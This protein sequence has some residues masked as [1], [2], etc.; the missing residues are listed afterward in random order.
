MNDEKPIVVVVNNKIRNRAGGWGLSSILAGILSWL[1]NHSV[2]WCVV[3]FLL[4]WI[5]LLYAAL[6]R[7]EEVG[8]VLTRVF[9]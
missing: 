7:P 9:G 1:L 2:G 8:A 6:V 5:Y 3:H 4:G